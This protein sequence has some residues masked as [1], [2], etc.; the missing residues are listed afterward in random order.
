MCNATFT[1]MS[2]ILWGGG[3]F[4]GGENQST[5]RKSSTCHKS[6]TNIMWYVVSSTLHHELDSNSQF[7]WWKAP[8][9]YSRQLPYDHDPFGIIQLSPLLECDPMICLPEKSKVTRGWPNFSRGDKPSGH[10]PT[11]V[12]IGIIYRIFFAT[13]TK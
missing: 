5:Q 8:I 3:S 10:T 12:I 7:Y 11:R 9:I 6:L 1:N 2:V 13:D 4:I